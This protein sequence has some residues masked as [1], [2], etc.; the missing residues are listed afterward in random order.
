MP[1]DNRGYNLPKKEDDDWH[2]PVNENWGMID[3]DVQAAIDMAQQALEAATSDDSTGTSED[4]TG[5]TNSGAGFSWDQTHV[6]TTWLT[7]ADAN[8]NLNVE[9]VTSLD[10]TGTGSITEAVANG[11]DQPTVVVFDVGGVIDIGG[12]PYWRIQTP[13]TYIAGQTAPYPGISM[14]RGGPRVQAQNVIVEHVG[15][16]CGDD[17]NDPH[18][19]GAV[20]IDE[21]GDVLFDHCTAAWGTDTNIRIP[22]GGGPGAF[23]NSINAEALND[24]SHPEAPHGYGFNARFEGSWDIL[25]NLWSH[26]W[27][28]NIRGPHADINLVFANNYIW[29]WGRRLYHGS[30]GGGPE[31]DCVACVAEA[32]PDTV[33]DQGDRGGLFD[34]R[35]VTCFFDDVRYPSEMD[36]EDAN[37]T[38]VNDPLNLAA[39]LSATDLKAASELKAFLTPMVGPRPADRPPHEQ[40]MVDDFANRQ[41]E[42]ID[43]HTDV[44]GYP[45]YASNTRA[46]LPPETD[47]LTWVQG[48]TD[49][50]ELGS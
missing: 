22:Q 9:T 33:L 20:T 37:T 27:K 25:G 31:F 5:T 42:I 41:G 19:A 10:F 35:T 21:P 8:D 1:T 28:R 47:V 45:D 34:N 29:N 46:L 14:I 39:G 13:N 23:I 48:Y 18:K 36:R 26:H 50:V 4:S 44:G 15:F 2:V 6:D 40:R 43:H 16:Y 17:V 32:G 30:K 7:D 11:G 3:A 38:Y 24:S 49:A 12:G